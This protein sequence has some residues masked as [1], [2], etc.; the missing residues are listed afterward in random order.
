MGLWL[1]HARHTPEAIIATE[2]GI[3]RAS[4]VKR[5]PADQQ[6]DDERIKRIKGAPN[7]W[8]LD[9][10]IEPQMVQIEDRRNPVLDPNH[11]PRVGKMGWREEVHVPVE[12]T[13]VA[14]LTE[15]AGSGLAV[16]E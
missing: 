1:G 15:L 16:D 7:I 5:L 2:V 14:I 11:E 10:G 8:K 12:R 13:R 3:V 4:A 9:A 6:W